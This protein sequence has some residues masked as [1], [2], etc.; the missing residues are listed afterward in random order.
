MLA[1]PACVLIG[2]LQELSFST[3]TKEESQIVV[4]V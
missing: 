2:V 4:V 3:V 1:L